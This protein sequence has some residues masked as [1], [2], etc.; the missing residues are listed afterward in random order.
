MALNVAAALMVE[1]VNIVHSSWYSNQEFHSM[2]WFLLD[3][4]V[5]GTIIAYICELFNESMPTPINDLG[6]AQYCS[7]A[8][9]KKHRDARFLAFVQQ[10][11]RL[12]DCTLLC[13]WR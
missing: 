9:Y 12:L 1:I 5:L 8:D 13:A 11:C 3:I 10:L 6:E 7:V 2:A 4:V